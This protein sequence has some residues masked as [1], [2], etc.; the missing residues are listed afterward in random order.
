MDVGNPR[1][2]V[3]GGTMVSKI[4]KI[5]ITGGPCAGKTTVMSRLTEEFREREFRVLCVPEAAT[6]LISCGISARK[7]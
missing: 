3:R 1:G 5:V 7:L 6:V 2:L 4:T